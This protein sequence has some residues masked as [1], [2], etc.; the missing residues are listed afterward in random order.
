MKTIRQQVIEAIENFDRE[1]LRNMAIRE[2]TAQTHQWVEVHPAGDVTEAEE[3]DN[4]TTHWVTYPDKAVASI[5]EISKATGEKCNCDACTMYN[6]YLLAVKYDDKESFIETYSEEDWEYCKSHTIEDVLDDY[7]VLKGIE[8]IRDE[9]LEAVEAIQFGYF[10]DETIR[11]MGDLA[12]YINAA[13]EWPADV[14]DIIEANGWV[15]DCGETYGVCHNGSEKIVMDGDGK[16]VVTS[17]EP[18]PEPIYVSFHIGR[19]GRF[20]N[21]G[22]L[23]FR[24]E[25]DFQYLIAECSDSCIIISEDVDG[26]TLPDEDWTL[27]D[28]GGNVILQGR[29][30]ID[31]RTGRLEWDGEYDTDYTTTADEL[32]DEEIEA[33]KVSGAYIS[34][35]L[36]DLILPRWEDM[37]YEEKEENIEQIDETY[38]F[39]Q[40]ESAE[41]A[42]DNVVTGYREDTRWFSFRVKDIDDF[43]A[44]LVK[45]INDKNTNEL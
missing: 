35:E 2:H 41:E 21:P 25:E 11:T 12:D 6:D 7:E 4:N 1:T 29:S 10:D 18:E 9:M 42:A 37:T 33:I 24:G 40:Y 15:S 16:A 26:N 8:D 14:E 44:D 20:H 39:A 34:D 38:D 23:T 3:A 28:H 45:F 36:S 22:H 32:S 5:Y 13:D 31:A 30:E 19:G 43:R 27:E 17:C